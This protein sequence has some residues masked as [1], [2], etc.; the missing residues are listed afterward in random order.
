LVKLT[1]IFLLS[2][3]LLFNFGIFCQGHLLK[4][5]FLFMSFFFQFH[6]FALNNLPLIFVIFSLFFLFGYYDGGLVKL[7]PASSGFFLSCFFFARYFFWISFFFIMIL[8][9]GLWVYQI[10]PSW[11]GFSSSAL[12]FLNFYSSLTLCY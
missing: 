7:T 9:Y 11:L 8:Y 10:R 6:R 3:L 4:I 2:F 5:W 1:S 12:Y